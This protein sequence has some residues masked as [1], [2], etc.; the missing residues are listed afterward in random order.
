MK[1]WTEAEGAKILTARATTEDAQPL[2]DWI[3]RALTRKTTDKTIT[4]RACLARIL[5]RL[6]FMAQTKVYLFWRKNHVQA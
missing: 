3:K 6:S 1:A 2:T 4:Q 5:K